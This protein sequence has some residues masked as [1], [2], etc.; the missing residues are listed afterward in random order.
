MVHTSVIII[1]S[2][3][4]VLAFS[5]RLTPFG[6]KRLTYLTNDLTGHL[7]LPEKQNKVSCISTYISTL[8]R[9]ENIK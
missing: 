4:D 1:H 7:S 8:G 2:V 3:G 9:Y 6:C 5:K